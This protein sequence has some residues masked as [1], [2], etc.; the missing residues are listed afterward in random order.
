LL[1][2]INKQAANPMTVVEAFGDLA[3]SLA[4][5]APDKIIDLK[6]PQSMSDRVEQLISQKKESDLN[7]DETAE[8]ER[9]LALDLFISLTKA[10]ARLLLNA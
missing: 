1:S 8:L 6:A 10:K 4:Q 2:L 3:S 5:M 7:V 9:F